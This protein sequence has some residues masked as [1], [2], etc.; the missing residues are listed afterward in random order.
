MADSSHSPQ[1]K[2][3]YEYKQGFES[4]TMDAITKN[5]HKDFRFIVYP[6]SLGEQEQNKEEWVKRISGYMV[7]WTG[8]QV[9]PLNISHFSD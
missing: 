8:M 4:R 7:N 3:M 5:L 9:N 1:V 2:L 6:Q